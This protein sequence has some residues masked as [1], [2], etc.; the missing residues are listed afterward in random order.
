MARVLLIRHPAI[1]RH[2]QGRCYGQSDVGLSSAGRFAA[3][4]ITARLADVE[5]DGGGVSEIVSSPLRR[6][7]MLAAVMS[8][9][10]ALPISFEPRLK[11][12]NF[13]IWEGQPWTTIWSQSGDAMMGMVE[14]PHEFRPG[15]GETT[16]E[17]RDRAMAWLHAL[18]DDDRT[19]VAITH[20]GPICAIRG[21]L[22]GRPVREWPGL[23]P[24]YGEVIEVSSSP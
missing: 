4:T 12:C 2:W 19:I 1:A 20:G 6:A 10:M 16:F 24:D 18:P 13:G 7:R 9:E 23:A 3:R 17:V 14:R 11:E 8:R 22:E 15:G 21:T 5:L